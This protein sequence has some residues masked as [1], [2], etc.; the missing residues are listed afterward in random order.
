MNRSNNGKREWQKIAAIV[1]VF[2]L[3]VSILTL[4]FGPGILKQIWSGQS[5]EPSFEVISVGDIVVEAGKEYTDEWRL[6]IPVKLHV[7]IVN[8]SVKIFKPNFVKPS[9]M[10]ASKIVVVTE[11][12]I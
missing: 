2:G 7:V 6:T 5:S 8:I 9:A 1:A 12:L 11:Y 4:L 10:S 3:L